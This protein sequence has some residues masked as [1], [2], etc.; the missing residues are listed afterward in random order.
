[1]TEPEI[2]GVIIKP[3]SEAMLLAPDPNVCQQCAKDHDPDSPHDQQSL[4]YQYWF[5]LN[6]AKAGREERW[7]TW[8][9]AMEHCDPEVQAQWRAALEERGVDVDGS[10]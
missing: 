6:E 5:R 1:M 3:F 2:D 7:P 10:A 9:D 8:A 4:F